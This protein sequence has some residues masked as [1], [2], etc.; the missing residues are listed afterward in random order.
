MFGAKS[1]R[2]SLKSQ[3][4]GG[5]ILLEFQSTAKVAV[6]MSRNK[7]VGCESS[8]LIRSIFWGDLTKIELTSRPLNVL[9]QVLKLKVTIFWRKN[10]NRCAF[11]S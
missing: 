2:Q 6:P 10:P 5:Q 9:V 7:G 4:A 1:H 3:S 8:V 11:D